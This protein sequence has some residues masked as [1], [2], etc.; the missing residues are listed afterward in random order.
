VVDPLRSLL[1]ASHLLAPDDLASTVA[2]HARSMGAR[3][4]VIYLVDYEQATLVPLP[5]AGVPERQELAIEAT[6]AGRAFRRV[7]V[8]DSVA[9]GGSHRL[10]LPLLDGVERL[11]VVEL[12]LA[13]EPDAELEEDFRALISLVA[14]LVVVHGAYGDVF[15]RLRR[16]RTFSLAA[17]IQWGLLPPLTFGTERIVIT[18]G[19]EPAYDIGGDTFDYAVNGDTADVLI[20]DSVGHGLPA[21]V[22]ASVAVGAYRHARR[23]MLDL[24]DI[25]QQVD[26]AIAGQFGASQFATAVL[27]RLDLDTGR[28]RWINAGHPPPLILRGSSLVRPPPCPPHR[29]LGLQDAKPDYCETRLEP[30]D[31]LLLYT[32]GITEARSPDGEFFGEQRL[33]DFIA[34]A[35]AAGDPAPEMVRRLM[36]RLLV[37]QADQLQDDATIVVLEWRTGEEHRLLP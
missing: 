27:A 33:A 9:R 13:A 36:R 25:A 4:T 3:E 34:A 7:E 14:E 10:W 6:M 21:A 5:G 1:H 30:G 16:R 8:V 12:T 24:P 28:L 23:T 15:T 32:D 37:H 29:P 2:A 26:A 22:L 35:V 17:E 31:R 20:L 18:G 19:L 11:G